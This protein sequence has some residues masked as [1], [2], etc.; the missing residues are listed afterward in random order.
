MWDGTRR[1]LLLNLPSAGRLLRPLLTKEA[2]EAVRGGPDA[3]AA[4]WA[5]DCLTCAVDQIMGEIGG[6]VW[7]GVAFERLLGAT[8]DQ[9][10]ETLE[11]VARIS[12]QILS[13]L[14]SV[15]RALAGVSDAFETTTEDIKDQLDRLIYPGF[16]TGV[17]AAR[18]SDVHRY[19]QA[20]DRRLQQLPESSDRDRQR[21][22][23]VRKLEVQHDRLRESLPDSPAVLE[24]AWMLQELRVSLFAQALGTRGKVSEKRIAQAMAAALTD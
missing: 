20:I 15:R 3:T 24:V 8:R 4:D 13:T 19:L 17:G 5:Q 1:L 14:R 22:A 6:L 16:V 9:L 11:G 18:L 23:S 10:H 12:L 21:M 2:T 7:D